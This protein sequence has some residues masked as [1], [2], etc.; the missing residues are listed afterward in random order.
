MLP[1]VKDTILIIEEFGLQIAR[2]EFISLYDEQLNLKGIS[3]SSST[4]YPTI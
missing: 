2:E 3:A 4:D 1:Y